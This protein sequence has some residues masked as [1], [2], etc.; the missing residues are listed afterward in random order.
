[1]VAGLLAFSLNLFL[2]HEQQL[3]GV[4]CIAYKTLQQE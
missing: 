3:L 2:S 4:S 1:M